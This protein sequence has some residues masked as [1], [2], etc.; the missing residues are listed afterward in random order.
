MADKKMPERSRLTAAENDTLKRLM[1]ATQILS[2]EKDLE[3]RLSTI[4]RG[5]LLW[6]Q[7][8]AATIK[9]LELVCE[10]MPTEQLAN[11]KKN[12]DL[13]TYQIGVK[14]PGK[15]HMDDYGMWVSWNWVQTVGKAAGEKCLTCSFDKQQ[16]RSCP[17]AKALDEI[18]NCKHENAA[19]CGYMGLLF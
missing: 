16:A 15:P 4:P 11:T 9:L 3:R 17:L 8:R 18:P 10:T 2:E 12:L 7:A 14:R 1:V 6:G 19:G 13:V 5:K